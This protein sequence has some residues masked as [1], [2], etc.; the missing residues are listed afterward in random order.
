MSAVEVKALP[1][2]G[3]GL[4]TVRQVEA[5]E[6]I[7]VEEPLLLTVSQE[8]KDNACAHCLCWLEGCTGKSNCSFAKNLL[9]SI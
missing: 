5:G 6:V 4:I 7:I 2:R 9:V 3:R 1:G 8:A